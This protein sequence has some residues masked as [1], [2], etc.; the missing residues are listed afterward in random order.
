[1]DVES[2]QFALIRVHPDPAKEPLFCSLL[3][4][5]G[6]VYL[7]LRVETKNEKQLRSIYPS[8]IS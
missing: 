6:Q 2:R 3:F 8:L 7:V 4:L 5:P 1:L